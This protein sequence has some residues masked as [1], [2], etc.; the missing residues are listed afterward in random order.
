MSWGWIAA[1][2]FAALFIGLAIYLGIGLWHATFR[3]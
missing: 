1:I 3:G 2:V